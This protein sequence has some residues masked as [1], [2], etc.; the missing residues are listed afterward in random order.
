MQAIFNEN[1]TPA[2]FTYKKRGVLHFTLNKL[3]PCII[4]YINIIYETVASISVNT[5]YI[6]GYSLF[7]VKWR[8]PRFLYVN[9]AGVIFSLKIACI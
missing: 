2:L 1:I 9:K 6:N 5:N 8:T 4:K 3:Y 7:N